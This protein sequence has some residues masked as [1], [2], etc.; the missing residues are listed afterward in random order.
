MGWITSRHAIRAALG[1]GQGMT[2]YVAGDS[3][4]ERELVERARRHGVRIRT[5]DRARLRALAGQDARGIALEVAD[6]RA[7]G[8]MVD[9]TGWLASHRDNPSSLILALDHITDP[10]NLGAILR[11]GLLH[12]V[13]LFVLPSRRSASGTETV[14]RS[15]AGA[16]RHVDIAWV[17]NLRGALRDCRDAGYWI[18]GAEAGGVTVQETRLDNRAVLV[19]G[20][21]GKGLSPAVARDCDALV[22]I[23]A[24]VP[25]RAGVDSF[26]VSVATGILLYEYRRQT[27][28]PDR[29]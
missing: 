18:Y 13:D 9:F 1:A 16:L 3:G 19:V 11:S 7:G 15:S 26:N 6:D 5:V 10:H 12:G 22:S 29:A 25:N 23:P 2:L 17:G 21:E 14:E 28:L 20:A 8:R 24:C 27:G 4:R